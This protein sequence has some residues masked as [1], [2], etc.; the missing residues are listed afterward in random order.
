M[1]ENQWG[2]SAMDRTSDFAKENTSTITLS[3]RFEGRE[4]TAHLWIQID[5]ELQSD[6]PLSDQ[7]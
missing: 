5:F 3:P 6:V 2:I 1:Q 7:F 4:N